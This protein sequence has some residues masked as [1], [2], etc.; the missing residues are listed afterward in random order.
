MRIATR[1]QTAEEFVV[2][3]AQHVGERSIRIRRAK[4][5]PN[6]L[7]RRFQ[8]EL[9]DGTPVLRGIGVP[10]TDPT[11]PDDVRLQVI[12]L[13]TS[14]RVLFDQMRPSTV[15]QLAEAAMTPPKVARALRLPRVVFHASVAV[16]AIATL[17]G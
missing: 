16:L 10:T 9:A 13:D 12:A 5:P 7:R 3:F 15:Q 2:A 17:V 11:S 4:A 8:F 1:C 6:A 14:S